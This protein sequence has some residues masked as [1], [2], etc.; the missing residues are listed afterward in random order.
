[1]LSC[2]GEYQPSFVKAKIFRSDSTAPHPSIDLPKVPDMKVTYSRLDMLNYDRYGVFST[3]ITLYVTAINE[4]AK[5]RATFSDISF[6]LRFDGVPV[7]ELR[8]EPFEIPRNSTKTLP[9][10]V[11]SSSIPLEGNAAEEI[12]ASLKRDKITFHLKGG[13]RVTWNIGPVGPF[14]FRTHLFCKLDF[15]PTNGSSVNSHSH[16]SPESD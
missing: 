12:D 9:Y 8:A 1:M 3:Q 15:F 10:V 2:H 7:A 6:V 11:Q 14:K 16:C 4:N 5:A 13:S